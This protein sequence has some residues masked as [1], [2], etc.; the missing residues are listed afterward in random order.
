MYLRNGWKNALLHEI[1]EQF[2]NI[3]L[4]ILKKKH[5]KS[6]DTAQYCAVS[7]DFKLNI[8]SNLGRNEVD[9]QKMSC[10]KDVFSLFTAK[11]MKLS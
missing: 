4:G 2:M 6:V 10:N 9:S 5:F 11:R 1:A 3:T 7:T 8:F